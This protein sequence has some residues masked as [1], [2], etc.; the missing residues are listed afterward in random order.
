MKTKKRNQSVF[1]NNN[2]L[3][4]GRLIKSCQ[5]K[6]ILNGFYYKLLNKKRSKKDNEVSTE[7]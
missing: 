6:K 5:K 1:I 3:I 4:E 2:L 7:F